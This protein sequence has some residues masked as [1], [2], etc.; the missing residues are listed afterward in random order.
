[1]SII[2]IVLSIIISVAILVVIIKAI[3]ALLFWGIAIGFIALGL[4]MLINGA[5]LGVIPIIIGTGLVFKS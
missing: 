3:G 2:I 4:W 5:G 1:M